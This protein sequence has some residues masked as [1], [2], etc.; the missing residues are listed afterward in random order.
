MNLDDLKTQTSE[1]LRHPAFYRSPRN[2]RN[3]PRRERKTM[4]CGKISRW[5]AVSALSLACFCASAL[6]RDLAPPTNCNQPAAHP[7]TS[8]NLP[9]HPFDVITTSDGC[10][11][12]VSIL[13]SMPNR[14]SESGVAVLR[15]SEGKVKLTHFAPFGPGPAGMALTHDGNLLI[16]ADG[17]DV[18]FLDPARLISG[19][20]EPGLG[21]LTDGKFSASVFPSV[22][23]D[24]RTLF[25][26]DERA[27]TVTVIDLEK[28]RHSGF[29]PD[30]IIGKIPVGAAPVS[31]AFSHDQRYLFVTS[32]A[33]PPNL[34]WPAVCAPETP[35]HRLGSTEDAEGAVQVVDVAKARTEPAGAVVSTVPAGCSPVRVAV[36]PDGEVVYATAR[37]SNSLLAFNAAKLVSDPEHARIE[38]VPVGPAPVGLAVAEGGSKVVVTNSNRFAGFKHAQYLTVVDA[39]RISEGQAAALGT[40]PAGVFPRDICVS[41][42]GRTIFVTNFLSDT[43]ML[44][45]LDRIPLKQIQ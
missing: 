29:A 15:R 27:K 8:V 7:T 38:M 32:E 24:D 5:L 37:G 16:V 25:V 21:V 41:A 20:G 22:T 33:S 1:G 13:R 6:P 39:A 12:F 44:L 3:L 10:W 43:L 14:V 18:I 42:D 4:T 28:A 9:G 11:I 2:K 40:I 45:D 26:S 19:K 35:S 17:D 30:S 34:R 31:L 36:S 23:A